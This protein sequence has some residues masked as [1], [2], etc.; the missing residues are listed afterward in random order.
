MPRR[1]SQLQTANSSVGVTYRAIPVSGGKCQFCQLRLAI[2]NVVGDD[3]SSLVL[4]DRHVK[5]LITFREWAIERGL[6]PDMQHWAKQ[7]GWW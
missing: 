6:V 4:C 5:S 1:K 2:V 7:Q 3:G